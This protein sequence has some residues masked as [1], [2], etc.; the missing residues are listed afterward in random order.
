MCNV[1]FSLKFTFFQNL[2]RIWQF[3]CLGHVNIIVYAK[4]Y[5]I[6]QKVQEIGPFHFFFRIWTSAKPLPMT[7]PCQYQCICT[8]SSYYCWRDRAI[9]TFRIRSSAK[10]RPMI[11][12]SLQTLRLDLV[13]INVSSTFYLNCLNCSR[14]SANGSGTKLRKPSGHGH[15]DYRA[16]S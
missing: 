16:H 12:V 13:N 5:Q 10:P 11:N 1:H 6:F 2:D 9:F 7:I 14:V 3:L 8:I 15:C 4:Y